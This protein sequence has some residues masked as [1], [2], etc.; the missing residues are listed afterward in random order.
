VFQTWEPDDES[1]DLVSPE[2][3]RFSR[4]GSLEGPAGKGEC[5]TNVESTGGAPGMTA[6]AES[7][8]E[9]ALCLTHDVDRPFKTPF[10]ALY[11]TLRDR[12]TRHL[13]TLVSKTNPYWQFDDLIAIE[14]S[15]G[16]RSALYFLSAQSLR[17]LAV[18]G[19][20]DPATYVELLGRYDVRTPAITNLIRTLDAGGWE[21]GLHGS[22]HSPTN[23]DRLRQEK[24][25]IESVLGDEIRGGR[26]HYL[27][28]SVPETWHHHRDIGL[29]YD[30]S[31]GSTTEY[32]FQYGYDVRR[33]F[34][35]EFVVFPLTVMDQ[36]LPDPETEFEETLTA[37][38]SLLD[39]A[40]ANDAVMTALWHPRLFSDS[41]FPGHRRLYR[42]FVQSGLDRGAWV[43]PPGDYYETF[44]TE[45]SVQ[46]T[47][48]QTP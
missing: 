18:E 31:L 34:D 42:T 30:C 17:E 4:N 32:G 11:Y 21:V 44:L 12:D 40:A 36:T 7:E 39:E 37:V 16:V 13:D 5:E 9:F 48:S 25:R 20:L 6:H 2:D 24:S 8:Y 41:D 27:H 47:A 35:D 33:P 45:S 29:T 1:A 28:L 3:A 10:H 19:L 15:L 23:R 38:E 43:G 14:E 26:Q 46:S 22:Y